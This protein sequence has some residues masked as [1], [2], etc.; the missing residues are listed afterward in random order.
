MG[1]YVEESLVKNEEIKYSAH[2]WKEG[3]LLHFIFCL[4]IGFGLTFL[5]KS[6]NTT[7]DGGE[8]F[9]SIVLGT[10][11]WIP[12]GIKDAIRYFTTEMAITNQRV[13]VK[14]GFI[15]QDVF[16]NRLSKIESTNVSISLLGRILGYGTV[17]VRGTGDSKIAVKYI[18]NPNEFK[19]HLT[20]SIQDISNN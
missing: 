16:D 11:I 19:R 12:F 13:L 1:K 14:T 9:A 5:V 6:G 17:I 3:Y 4:F 10:I 18:S 2:P 7:T 8:I 15:R 20:Q